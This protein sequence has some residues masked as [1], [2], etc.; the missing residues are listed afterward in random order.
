MN[1]LTTRTVDEVIR[2]ELAANGLFYVEAQST[3]Y[4][5]CRLIQYMIKLSEK[6][7]E[8]R[9]Q[10]A[11]QRG[12]NDGEEFGRDEMKRL[13]RNNLERILDDD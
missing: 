11:Y 5:L 13:V 8:D 10:E 7:Q 1:Q 2:E 4:N 9:E 3:T 12:H 6:A